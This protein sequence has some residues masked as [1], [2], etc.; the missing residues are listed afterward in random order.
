MPTCINRRW[1]DAPDVLYCSPTRCYTTSLVAGYH[2]E[3]EWEDFPNFNWSDLTFPSNAGGSDGYTFVRR[4]YDITTALLC[5]T[6]IIDPQ[7]A[8]QV[9]LEKTGKNEL[10]WRHWDDPVDCCLGGPYDN[11][12]RSGTRPNYIP[13]PDCGDFI[14]ECQVCLDELNNHCSENPAETDDRCMR[15]CMLDENI[16]PS[17]SVCDSLDVFCAQGNNIVTTNCQNYYEKAKDLNA[18]KKG[19][20][21]NSMT[22]YCSNGTNMSKQIC[23]GSDGFCPTN[24]DLCDTGLKNFCSSFQDLDMCA[25]YLPESTYDNIKQPAIDAGVPEALLAKKPQCFYQK[26]AAEVYL[27]PDINANC[28]DTIFCIQNTTVNSNG[29][30]G[31]SIY[32]DSKCDI[33]TG[34][35]CVDGT[36][37]DS[38]GFCVD[39]ECVECRNVGDCDDDIGEQCIDN[40]CI[41]Q[42]D[43]DD[44]C[45]PFGKCTEDNKCVTCIEDTDCVGENKICN[46][47]NQCVI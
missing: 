46:S 45:K 37:C 36:T 19:I 10:F 33:N 17:N 14:P 29:S 43:D 11:V 5:G 9:V 22:N 13:D 41:V 47:S 8:S 39:E 35:T 40:E 30:V 15:Y 38:G 16:N 44:D 2:C 20:W 18:N 12:W 7:T 34:E 31:G 42:C 26:C 3:D 23:S 27:N 25:C 24:L 32:V 6:P 21:E 4:N 28:P 1:D